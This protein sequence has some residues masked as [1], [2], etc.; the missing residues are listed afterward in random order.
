M[1]SNYEA[2]FCIINAGF[3]DQV[4]FAARKAGAAGGTIFKG[5]GSSNRQAQEIFDI[6]VQPE[7]E[8]VMMIVPSSIKDD[9]L[10]Q[11]YN[12]CGL[13]TEGSGIVF[14]LPV[15][16][17]VGLRDFSNDDGSEKSE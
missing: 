17:A 4:L 15:S 5:H 3:A 2:V 12:S 10:K 7:K 8:V 13:D 6:I 11:I 14:S 9:V 1:K 16:A